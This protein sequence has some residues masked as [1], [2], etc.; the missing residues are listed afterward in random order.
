MAEMKYQ[1]YGRAGRDVPTVVFSAGLGGSHHFWRPQIEALGERFRIIGYDHRGTGANAEPLP[2]N[3]SIEQMAADVVELLDAD[4][5]EGVHF[6]GHAL[7]AII[8]FALARSNP[9]RVKSL[10]PVNGWMQVSK[11]TRRCFDARCDLLLSSG[12]EAYVKA[13]P[14]FLYPSA[15]LEAHSEEVAHEEEIGIKNFQGADNLLRRIGALL[16][17]DASPWLHELNC[18]MLVAATRDDVL[19]PWTCSQT[20]AEKAAKA[21][22]WVSAEGGHGFTA[23]APEEFNKRAASF[24]EHAAS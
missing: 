22:L 19:V 4:G 7:G 23:I 21:T 12:A 14:I 20:L 18:P 1:V 17:F 6:I 9:T 24:I 2:E 16:K 11:H 5:S 3:Y 10:I 8:G 15:W 13:Q